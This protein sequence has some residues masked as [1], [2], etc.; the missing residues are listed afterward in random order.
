MYQFYIKPFFD[1]LGAFLLFV[2]LTPV[3]LILSI[4]LSITH[5]S[6][7][8]FIQTRIGQHQKKFKI[9]KFKTIN[10]NGKTTRFL[11]FLRR[12]K[13]DELPQLINIMAM[14][15]SFVGPRPD[16]PGYYDQLG[17]KYKNIS[18]LKPGLTGYASLHFS[19]EEQILKS[20]SD[21]LN[22]N[23]TVIFPQKL[24][25]NSQYAEDISF[26]T[27][28][29]IILKTVLLPFRSSSELDS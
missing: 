5:R 23:D 20:Q 18:K 2:F 25:L 27:D 12:S 16:I 17:E 26:S 15:M 1:F 22:Y 21:P 28:I 24:K 8:F 7:P 14:Q 29:K 19:N 9:F 13:L 6:S 3:L 10:K 4:I 11:A